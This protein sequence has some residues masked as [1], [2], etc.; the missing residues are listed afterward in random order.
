MS[1]LAGMSVD[2]DEKPLLLI[3]NLFAKAM[4]R[5]ASCGEPH[6]THLAS[7]IADSRGGALQS[8]PKRGSMSTVVNVPILGESRHG[9]KCREGSRP[10]GTNVCQ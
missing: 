1:K 9:A 5:G 10:N 2:C 4:L 8:P 7:D 3:A 6:I